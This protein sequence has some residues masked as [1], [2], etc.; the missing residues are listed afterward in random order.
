MSRHDD[1]ISLQHIIVHS[2]EA[3]DILGGRSSSEIEHDRTTQL[4]L[5]KLVEIV[6]EAAWRVSKETR[7]RFPEI[8]WRE[9]IA[10][11]NRLAHGYDSV[12]LDILTEIIRNRLPE[13]VHRLD[14]D[15]SRAET[16]GEPPQP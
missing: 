10:T 2:R 5:T 14:A 11:R 15:D 7:E 4:A 12:D 3:I 16:D 9:M 8:P 13:I 6:G 1:A